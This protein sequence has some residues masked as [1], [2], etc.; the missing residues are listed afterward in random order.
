MYEYLLIA[1]TIFTIIAFIKKS[2]NL[3]FKSVPYIIFIYLFLLF[4]EETSILLKVIIF[5]VFVVFSAV[6]VLY[7]E[8]NNAK[9][10]SVVRNVKEGS[11]EFQNPL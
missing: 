10:N 2:K 4:Y 7:E 1:A 11:N 8:N 9:R 3:F 5:S 6:I